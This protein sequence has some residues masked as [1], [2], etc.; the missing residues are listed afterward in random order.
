MMTAQKQ[1]TVNELRKARGMTQEQMALALGIPFT[2]AI[3]LDQRRH[4]PS[5]EN[6]MRIARLFGVPVESIDFTPKPKAKGS[7][8][9]E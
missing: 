7:E 8:A 1:R 6:A 2:T 9:A 5:L 4:M 3:S